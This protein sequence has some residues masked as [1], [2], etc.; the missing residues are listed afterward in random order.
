M[1]QKYQYITTTLP[2]VNAAPHVGFAMELIRADIL[3]RYKKLMGYEVFFNTGTDE[4]G[5]K[6]WSDAEK[7]GEPVQDY[8]D[9]HSQNFREL[10]SMLH[11]SD[12]IH[13]IRTT[14]S[15]HIAAAQQFWKLVEQ[16][17]Y[18]YK[19][20][21]TIKYCVGCELEKTDS[22]LVD[23]QCPIHPTYEIELIDEE[24]YFFKFSAFEKPLLDLYT[25]R[26]DFVLPAFRMH[27]I[28]SFVERGLQD[29]SIS[30]LS[31]KMP[32]GIPV[33]GDD[34]QVMYV[35]FDALV[36]YISTLGWN[37]DNKNFSDFWINGNPIQYCGKDNLRQQSAMW[38]AMLMAANIPCSSHVII[39]GFFNGEGGIKMSK[40]IGNVVTPEQIVS[41]YDVEALRLFV[42]KDVSLWEDSPFTMER[43][44]ASYQANL[45]NGLGNLLSRVLTMAQNYDVD[46][47]DIV[48][49]VFADIAHPAYTQYD[50]AA[51]TADLWGEIADLDKYITDT[52]PFKKFKTDP[53]GARA[54]VHHCITGL[55][56]ISVLLQPIM[57]VTSEK[58][59]E[60]ILK[61]EKPSEPLFGRK[62]ILI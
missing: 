7:L 48:F 50:Y 37:E 49:P 12:D 57:P 4:H 62:D 42:C 44:A 53:D 10:T 27:E 14:D 46:I 26:P 47:T 5:Q 33:P 31:S 17:G 18:I 45:V 60:L 30:R 19:K 38:Q 59:K 20:Q 24:N 16:N 34:S 15:N 61:R 8:V 54:D 43:F 56:R 58:M 6:L 1:T 41:Q 22:E 23:G 55:A 32:W 25:S 13:F 11:I 28:K 29:F 35:W 36:N 2:Y 9:R 21:Y 52:Q 51:V 39:N 3:A 40:S